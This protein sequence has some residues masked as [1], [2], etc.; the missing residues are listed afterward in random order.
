[1]GVELPLRVEAYDISNISGVQAVGSMIVFAGEKPNKN[2]YRKFKIKTVEGANDVA[3]MKEV[4]SRRFMNPWV[5]PDLI[6]LDGGKGHLNM[7]Q[8]LLKDLGFVIPLVAV[9]KGSTRKKLELH[10][11]NYKLNKEINNILSNEVVLKRITDEAHR[12]AIGYHR[13]IR[14]K[15]FI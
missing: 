10:I 11:G 12:F 8:K 13:Q 14:R 2:E 4:L 6:I 7:A 1:M 5:Q 3:M 15:E 9:A